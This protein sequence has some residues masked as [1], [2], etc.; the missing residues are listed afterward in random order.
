[1]ALDPVLFRQVMARFATGITVVT[2]R[3]KNGM[4]VGVTI[5]SFTSVSLRPPLVLFCI[6]TQ[7]KSKKAFADASVFAVNILSDRQEE[8]SRH[9]ASQ[10]A[11]DWNDLSWAYG[12]HG[13]PVLAGTLGWLVCEKTDMRKAGDHHIILGKVTDLAIGKTSKPLLYFGSKYRKLKA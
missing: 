9:F 5:N 8:L 1:M 6:G 4:P 10:K 7:A 12:D 3:A 11:S 2:T 13:C